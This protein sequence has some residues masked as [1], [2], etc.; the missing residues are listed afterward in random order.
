MAAVRVPLM[1]AEERT[2]CISHSVDVMVKSLYNFIEKKG[3]CTSIS[4]GK[5]DLRQPTLELRAL[6]A[7]DQISCSSL[8]C[9][10]CRTL[11]NFLTDTHSI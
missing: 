4:R 9:E 7:F 2:E 10:P 1:L 6:S 5:K 11:D 8:S 3:A